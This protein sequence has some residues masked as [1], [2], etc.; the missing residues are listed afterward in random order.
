MA[1]VNVHLTKLS[2]KSKRVNI[3]LPEHI[4]TLMDTYAAAH[5][6]TRSRL[7]TQAA[8][9]VIAARESNPR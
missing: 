9:E 4:L 5:G 8:I 7:I 3:T 1:V 2:G 6:E